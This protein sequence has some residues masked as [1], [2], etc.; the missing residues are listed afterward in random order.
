MNGKMY[1]QRKWNKMLMSVSMTAQSNINTTK[2]K[3]NFE[4]NVN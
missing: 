4:V 3:K 2:V 1:V